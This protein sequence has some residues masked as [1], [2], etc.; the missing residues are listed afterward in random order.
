MLW[1]LNLSKHGKSRACIPSD[2]G[3]GEQ[4]MNTRKSAQIVSMDKQSLR[5]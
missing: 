4:S 1:L 5:V 3:E 2:A